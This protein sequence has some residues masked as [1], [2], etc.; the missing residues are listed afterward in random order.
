MENSEKNNSG[1]LGESKLGSQTPGIPTPGID[2]EALNNSLSDISN[3]IKSL[4]SKLNKG[5][6]YLTQG[7]SGVSYILDENLVDLRTTLTTELNEL[8][9]S[10][11]TLTNVLSKKLT[12]IDETLNRRIPYKEEH[13]YNT[14]SQMFYLA[15]FDKQTPH[16]VT[17]ELIYRSKALWN[18]MND[19]ELLKKYLD[20]SDFKD[21]KEKVIPNRLI[22][23]LSYY[24]V[25]EGKTVTILGKKFKSHKI[26]L[27]SKNIKTDESNTPNSISIEYD[28]KNLEVLKNKK[29]DF[30]AVKCSLSYIDDQETAHDPYYD[31]INLSVSGVEEDDIKQ[32]D[33][34]NKNYEVKIPINGLAK[35]SISCT[36]SAEDAGGNKILDTS[37][38]LSIPEEA[39]ETTDSGA[40]EET[41]E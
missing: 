40:G 17:K 36:F 10:I 33:K 4:N 15:S 3:E 30:L 25:E 27:K 39:E 16:D 41:T 32:Y 29:L 8:Q 20:T 21:G 31:K 5:N 12:K 37:I 38:N 1:L 6:T 2:N 34:E 18:V 28:K 7:F 9:S 11:T 35:Q 23:K 13:I 14:V 19:D 22:I 26:S 24:T